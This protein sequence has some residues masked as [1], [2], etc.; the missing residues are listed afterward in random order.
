MVNRTYTKI[1]KI[2][3]KLSSRLKLQLSGY[4]KYKPG[5]Q[6]FENN[7]KKRENLIL[8]GYQLYLNIAHK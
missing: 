6:L 7:A 1:Q 2:T 5:R 4:I 3:K 8:N